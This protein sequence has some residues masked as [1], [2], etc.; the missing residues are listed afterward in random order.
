[1]LALPQ[2][3]EAAP[4]AFDPDGVPLVGVPDEPEL[5]DVLEPEEPPPVPL[6]PPSL[7]VLSF[8]A[9]DSDLSAGFE[10]PSPDDFFGELL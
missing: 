2:A 5:P 3:P 1:M 4:V 9:L 8:L 10:S 7:D 6:L